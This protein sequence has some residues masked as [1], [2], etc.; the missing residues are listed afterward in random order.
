MRLHCSG[1]F[2]MKKIPPKPLSLTAADPVDTPNPTQRPS[3]ILTV[4]PNVDTETLLIHASETLA[5]LNAMTTDLA[6]ELEGSRRNVALGIQ[7][8]IVLGELLVNRA[9]ENLDLPDSVGS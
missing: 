5:S 6:F 1:S 8:M 2:T 9:L 7:Q 3:P 4:T